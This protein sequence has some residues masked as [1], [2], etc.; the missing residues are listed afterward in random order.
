MPTARLICIWYYVHNTMGRKIIPLDRVKLVKSKGGH[1]LIWKVKVAKGDHSV[2]QGVGC[3]EH[4]FTGSRW[5][6]A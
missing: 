2:T 1:L 4:G 6:L 3:S 5:S